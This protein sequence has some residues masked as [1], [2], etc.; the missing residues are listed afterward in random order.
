MIDEACRRGLILMVDHTF[1]FNGAVRRIRELVAT[2][3]L[4]DH[5]YDSVRVNLGLFQSDVNVIRDL[6]VHDFDSRLRAAGSAARRP[7]TGMSHVPG[8]QENIAPT[9]LS[10]TGG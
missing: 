9:R 7:A 8:G 5:Y 6:A 2:G 3:E 4:G 10:S 1:L